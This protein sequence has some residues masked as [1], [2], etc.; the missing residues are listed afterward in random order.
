MTA[1][2]WTNLDFIIAGDTNRLNLSPI[3]NLSSNLKQV[4]KVSTRLNPDKI[5]DVIIT[6]LSKY[7][8]EPITKP[9]ISND[10]GNGKPSDHLV[11][12]MKT[13]TTALECPPR[14]YTTVEFRP[15]TDSGLLLFG[16]WLADQTWDF[17]YRETDA[18]EKAKVFHLVL[19]KKFH[20]L[21]PIKTLKVCAEDKPWISHHLKTL[22]RKRK[23][24]FNKNKASLKW[25]KLNTQFLEKS[26]LEK[27][28]YYE[29]IVQDLLT[30]NTGKYS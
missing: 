27:H 9:P 14:H 7:Y 12:L 30:S 20:E 24:E 11:V 3:L 4:V 10:A 16:K 2:Y 1:K 29:N 21:F 13:I 5:L 15:I 6:T 18:H 17:L 22:D 28:S 23:R 25:G 8:Q 19:M 26:K